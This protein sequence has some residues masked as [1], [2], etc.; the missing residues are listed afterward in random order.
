M[1]KRNPNAGLVVFWIKLRKRGYTRSITGLYRI[2]RK[3][4]TGMTMLFRHLLEAIDN[5]SITNYQYNYIYFKKVYIAMLLPLL[6][7]SLL[8][9]H[10]S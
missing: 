10:I 7:H 2:L 6:H 8:T 4:A 5:I 1:R 3:Q 9:I